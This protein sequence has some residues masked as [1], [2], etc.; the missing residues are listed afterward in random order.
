L[1]HLFVDYNGIHD[2]SD[3]NNDKLV[4][5]KPLNIQDKK[6]YPKKNVIEF[7]QMSVENLV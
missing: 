3:V 5:E 1:T 4:D 6:D 2:Y 7:P